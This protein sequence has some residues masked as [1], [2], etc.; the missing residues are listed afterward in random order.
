MPR[1]AAATLFGDQKAEFESDSAFFARRVFFAGWLK[2]PSSVTSNSLGSSRITGD[3]LNKRRLHKI[4]KMFFSEETDQPFRS[5]IDCGCE[6]LLGHSPYTVQKVFVRDEAVFEY[7][8]CRECAERLRTELSTETQLAYQE[9]LFSTAD[10]SNRID[11]I[12]EP[13]EHEFDEWVESCLVCHKP[14]TEC[15]RYSLCGM[16]IGSQIAL[17]EFPAIVCD[18][19]EKQLSELTSKET[20]DRWD[21]FVEENFD[22]PPGIET[23]SPYTQPILI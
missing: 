12:R 19:C 5:C 17:G 21:R 15:Y 7:A 23:D 22:G 20:R 16:L 14:R 4:T 1:F 2:A 11:F 8:M 13:D 10:L 9:F 18:D 3:D 6:L